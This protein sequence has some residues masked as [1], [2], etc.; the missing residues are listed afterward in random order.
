MNFQTDVVGVHF[1][2]IIYVLVC[3]YLHHVER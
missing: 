3:I 2:F 1:V